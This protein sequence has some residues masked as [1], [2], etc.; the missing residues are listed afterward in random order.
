MPQRRQRR[1]PAIT[2]SKVDKALSIGTKALTIAAGVAKLVNVEKKYSDFP[3]TGAF[4]NAGIFSCVNP[5]Q[6]GDTS[7][8]RDGDQVK[9]TKLYYKGFVSNTDPNS[10]HAVRFTILQDKQA[11]GNAIV[12]TDVHQI[13]NL[14][15][16]PLNMQNKL[17]FK[18]LHDQW[19]TLE[20]STNPGAG[21]SRDLKALEG[22]IDL[23]RVYPRDKGMRTVYNGPLGAINE[24]ASNPL[25]FCFWSTDPLAQTSVECNVRT[26]FID[27]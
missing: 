27:N 12:D 14:A 3:I 17:R 8:T 9:F 24:I 18:V 15:Y 23:Q 4:S 2:L 20:Q 19:F 26:R 16:S 25:Y 1:K 6:Q 21:G 5:L 11:D 22:Y 10:P 7:T 13:A